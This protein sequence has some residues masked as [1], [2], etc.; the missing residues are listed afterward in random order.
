M[1]LTKGAVLLYVSRK[2]IVNLTTN[3]LSFLLSL[4]EALR[5]SRESMKECIN[6]N[7]G[8]GDACQS[9]HLNGSLALSIFLLQEE[10]VTFLAGPP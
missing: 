7:T 3:K 6:F 10:D 5:Q 2:I 1:W 4:G 8:G 9:N